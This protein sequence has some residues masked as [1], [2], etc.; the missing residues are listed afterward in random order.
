MVEIALMQDTAH[1]LGVHA[2][3]VISATLP[4]SLGG[5]TWTLRVAGICSPRANWES[6]N[7]FQ[8]QSSASGNIYPVLAS[9]S[10]I[11]PRIAPLQVQ[12]TIE[13]KR[14]FTAGGNVPF[15]R[16]N[17][18]YPFDTSQVTASNAGPLS[19]LATTV[20]SDIVNGLSNLQGTFFVPNPSG[21][22]FDVL[23]GYY[24]RIYAGEVVVSASLIL[25][26]ALILFLLSMMTA[27]LIERQ[28]APH[29][30]PHSAVRA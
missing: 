20:Q 29:R 13:N 16:L 19:T 2:G 15:F 17:W 27:A 11:L 14:L 9:N 23:P 10:A 3:S 6:A 5:G 18:S 8:V 25:I 7:T 12:L 21:V 26:F 30:A 4:Q 1:S 28:A 22:L 24:Q